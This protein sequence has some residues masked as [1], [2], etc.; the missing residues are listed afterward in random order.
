LISQWIV[1]HVTE[2]YTKLKIVNRHVACK[3]IN[4]SW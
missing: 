1:L 2:K 3:Q 4:H